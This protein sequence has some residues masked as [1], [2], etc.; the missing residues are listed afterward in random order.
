[1]E[2]EQAIVEAPGHPELY[3][4]LG[5]LALNDRR[6]AEAALD[7]EK[8]AAM[9]PPK[10]WDDEKATALQRACRDGLATVAVSR[11]DWPAVRDHLKKWLELEPRSSAA[12]QRLAMVLFRLDQGREAFEE[13]Q[14]ASKDDPKLEPPG[15]TMARFYAQKPDLEKAG[16]WV[17]SAIKGAPRTP[18]PTWP[19]PTGCSIA[20][21][22]TR[23]SPRPKSSRRWSPSRRT[24]SA[25]AARSPAIARTIRPPSGISRS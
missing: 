18:A 21:S 11:Q 13:L 25:F 1:M 3:V 2:L 17:E 10:G 15:V 6:L 9:K 16:E 7:F 14:K 5:K 19:R 24:S 20:G 22:P 12:R 4:L 8:A 23:P